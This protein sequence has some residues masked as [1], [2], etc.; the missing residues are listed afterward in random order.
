VLR[1]EDPENAG[2]SPLT[3]RKAQRANIVGVI[4]RPHLVGKQG[5]PHRGS[6][7]GGCWTLHLPKMKKEGP[8]RSLTA[9]LAHG[10]VAACRYLRRSFAVC[11]HQ[12]RALGGGPLVGSRCAQQRLAWST[13]LF[14]CS[15]FALRVSPS[16]PPPH[17][18]FNAHAQLLPFHS[19]HSQ[20]PTSK[21]NQPPPTQCLLPLP[22]STSPTTTLSP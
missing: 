5:Y 14:R 9:A 8:W 12:R 20:N 7:I 6:L 17:L 15:L 10:W 4:P 1:A 16:Q 13:R 19:H 18:H 22:P 11:G 3:R 21:P 2:P